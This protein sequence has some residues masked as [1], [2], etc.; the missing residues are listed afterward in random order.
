MP[1]MYL[2]I[3]IF[4]SVKVTATWKLGKQCV[5]GN[6]IID[7]IIK[8]F[9][10]IY[11]TSTLQLSRIVESS[12]SYLFIEIYQ[13]SICSKFG[14]GSNDMTSLYTKSESK[15]LII[16]YRIYLGIY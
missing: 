10:D 1:R 11:H 5:T 14:F 16:I 15:I 4:S 12:V 6:D 8:F 3:N 13:Q 7:D 2:N 9:I